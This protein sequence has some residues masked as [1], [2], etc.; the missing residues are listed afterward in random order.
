MRW[1]MRWMMKSS[2]PLAG[3]GRTEPSLLLGLCHFSF[4]GVVSS[5]VETRLSLI[6]EDACAQG[7]AQGKSR[8]S[9]RMLLLCLKLNID[10]G[11][12]KGVIKNERLTSSEI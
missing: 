9:H 3:C 6:G 12:P 5:V 1:R 10:F 2:S 11:G 7:Q 8:Y 4:L